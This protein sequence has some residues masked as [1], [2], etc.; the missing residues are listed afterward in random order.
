MENNPSQML[1]N[2]HSIIKRVETIIHSM[3][4][5]WEKDA[6]KYKEMVGRLLYF[7]KEYSDKFHHYKEEEV[8]FPE[9]RNHPDF[10]LDEIIDELEDHHKMF[11]EYAA[12]IRASVE[13][14][15]PQKAQEVLKKYI[16]NLLDH[17]AIE[18]DELFSMAEGLFSSDEFEKLYFR[19][20]DIDR[21]LGEK[22]KEELEKIPQELE[23][24]LSELK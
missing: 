3:D 24:S 4:K 12:D 9:M 14:D 5:L 18:D 22:F 15:Q 1:M 17:I 8:L 21:E 11:R 16:S 10:V 7:F 19:F 2:E 6:E 20:Q 13:N 23:D